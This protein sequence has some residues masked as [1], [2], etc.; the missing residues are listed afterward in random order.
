MH[1]QLFWFFTYHSTLLQEGSHI[2]IVITEDIH[3][4]ATDLDGTFLES[5]NRED[6]PLY[7]YLHD[8]PNII[9][10]FNS[11]RNIELI[12]PLLDDMSIPTPHYIIGDVGASVLDGASLEPIQPLQN[13]ISN[14]WYK[15]LDSIADLRDRLETL[16]RQDQPQERRLSY[17]VTSSTI[18]RELVDELATREC[19]VLHSNEIYLDILPKGT[20]KGSTLEALVQHL[21]VPKE[22]VIVAGDTLNDLSMYQHGFKG[23]VLNNAET[24]LKEAASQ[25]EHAYF[26]KAPGTHGILEAMQHFGI[27]EAEEVP[28]APVPAYGDADLVMVYHRQ[29][30]LEVVENGRVVRKKHTSPNGILPTLLGFFADGV[31]GSWVAWSKTESRT[32]EGFE[33]YVEVDRERYAHLRVCRV[34]LTA[35][36]V[37]IFYEVFSKEALWLL[38]HSFHEKAVFNHAHW[39]HFCE[40]NRI[41]AENTAAEAAEGAVVWIHDYNLWMVPGYLRQ[42]RPDVKIAFYHHT[43]FPAADIFNMFPWRRDIINSLLQCDYI[44]F[45]I[46]QYIDNFVNTVRSNTQIEVNSRK[47][48]APLFKTYGCAM[49]VDDYADSFTTELNTVRLGAHPVGINC[50]YIEQLTASDDVHSL[51]RKIRDEIGDNKLIV[52]IE[53]TDYTKGPVDKLKAYE[54][55]LETHPEMRGK[56]NLFMVCTPP[57]KGMAIYDEI[58]QDIAYHVGLINGR[59][60]TYKWTPINYVSRVIPF[61]DVV[62]YNCAADIGWVTPLRDGLNLVSKE[63]VAA[64]H[65]IGGKGA[66]VLSEFAGAAVELHGAFLANP[67]DPVEMSD[68]LAQALHAPENER[69]SRLQRMS[70]IIHRYDVNAWG[71]DFLSS[72]TET[73]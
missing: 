23:V 40:V 46:P 12:L 69:I 37:K 45:H 21:G 1:I 24:P 3:I 41:F 72:V 54:H 14:R 15:T 68:T 51:Y 4:L 26:S 48:A 33:K 49:G 70:N 39:K 17:Y 53:R 16:E 63:Y 7:R 38:L 25:I 44:G 27:A 61:E 32:P 60:G 30:F 64:Q 52:S 35:H 57:A 55:F 65:A 29:P 6:D 19:D 8:H 56:I 9:L 42:L 22:R 50:D 66:L 13:N 58:T 18:P 10:V 5:V 62:A 28:E 11:G 71:Q 36:D 2:S 47:S 31:K 34:P 59:F 73:D 20:S 67:Y 43:P